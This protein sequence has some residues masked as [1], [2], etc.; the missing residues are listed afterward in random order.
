MNAEFQAFQ[1]SSATAPTAPFPRIAARAGRF[2]S[3]TRTIAEETAVA[4]TYNGAT[5][6]VMMA[7]P[8]DLEDFAVGFS[9]TEGIVSKAA[10]IS[11]LEVIHG[12]LGIE[13]RMWISDARISAYARRRR[14]LAGPTGCGLCGIESLGETAR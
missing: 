4:F 14:H 9:I 5:H 6:A 8:T 10:E 3:D 11:E 7:S 13:L 1:G 2:I 12:E